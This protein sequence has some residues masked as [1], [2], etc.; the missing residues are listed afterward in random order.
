VGASSG[1]GR[2]VAIQAA[3]A[4]ASVALGARRL[5]RLEEAVAAAG[6]D[7]FALQCDVRNDDDCTHIIEE[8]VRRFGGLDAVVYSSG[9]SPLVKFGE[10]SGEQLRAV[11]E[12]NVVGAA[13][14]AQAAMPHLKESSG[15]LLLLGSS[16]VGRPYP[17]LVAYTTSKAALHE[18]ARGIR[19]EIPWLRVTTFIVGP[20]TTEFAD[21]WDPDLAEA[22]LNRWTLEGYPW[23]VSTT[24]ERMADHVIWMLASQARIDEVLVMPDGP[25]FGVAE[26]I[27]PVSAPGRE[28]LERMRLN[29]E[30][31][32]S[33]SDPPPAG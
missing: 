30:A 18:L 10:A 21:T 29:Q 20:T 33:P 27:V 12:T 17:G 4:G 28:M 14:V 13:M 22:T 1:I 31:G 3:Q 16:A 2:A 24:V 32:K 23:G 15:R 8:T 26:P 25:E 6:G 5:E 11:L 19:N 9:M 7:S